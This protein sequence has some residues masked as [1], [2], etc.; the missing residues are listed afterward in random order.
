MYFFIVGVD[1]VNIREFTFG[2]RFKIAFPGFG[3][4]LA[5]FG[6]G[7]QKRRVSQNK[8]SNISSKERN[9]KFLPFAMGHGVSS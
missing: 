6:R 2:Q 9:A 7:R 4:M 5:P 8:R 1:C 3:P